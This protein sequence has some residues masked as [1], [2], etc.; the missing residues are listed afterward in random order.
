MFERVIVP[1]DGSDVAEKALAYGTEIA[2][3][4]GAR[5]VLVRAYAGQ[6]QSTRMLAMMPAEPAG[7]AVDPRAIQ[8]V[9]DT[10]R[11][12][13]QDSRDYLDA[14]AKELGAD[15]LAVE[16]VMVDDSAADAILKEANRETGALVVMCTHGRGGLSR[17]VFGST[18]QEVLHKVQAPILLIRVYESTNPEDG[19]ARGMDISIGAD[20]IG[21]GG[22][23]GEVHRVIA[24]SRTDRITDLVV[25][26]GFLFGRERIV[27]LS[28]VTSVENG[29]I[30]VDLD[31]KTFEIMDGYTDDRYRAPD[32]N[33]VGP[34]GF[35]R[36]DF[37]MDVTVAEGPQM[38]LG[39]GP[40]PTLGFPGGQ[41]ISPDDMSRPSISPGTTVL[42]S[43]GEKLGV[44]DEMA[45]DASSGAPTHLRI[46]SGGIFKHETT[47]AASAIAEISD[48]GVMLNLSKADIEKMADKT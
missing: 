44:V 38:G 11:L 15:G 47:I 25:K 41:Q 9:E 16:T 6:E 22:K 42:S 35:N 46:K 40:V 2:R 21:T 39:G 45:F 3:R 5:L 28:H 8:M 23:L 20:V 29:V 12:A 14:K 27:P 48:D 7:G 1:L 24:D 31:E 33:W 36:E 32:P 30:H 26:H 18:A 34:P 13:E 17:L 4:F 37:L 43:D 10:A 19:G